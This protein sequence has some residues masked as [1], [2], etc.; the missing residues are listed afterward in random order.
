MSEAGPG[1]PVEGAGRGGPAPGEPLAR[2]GEGPPP[3]WD[4]RPL[5]EAA[6]VVVIGGGII[7]VSTA[8]H[9]CRGG[10]RVVLLEKGR[11]A[12]E[13]SSRNWGFVRQQGRD[14][15]EMPLI[16]ESLRIWGRLAEEL[17]TD[18]GFR[19]AGTLYLAD[20]EEAL[21]RF[22][23]WLEIARAHQLDTRLLGP[24]EV[25]S[26]LPGA[27]GAWRGALATP[28][29]GRAEPARA[30]PALAAGAR[31]AG[32][33]IAEWT[34]AR[35]IVCAAGR[36]DAVVTERGA[37]RAGAVVVAGGAWSRLFCARHGVAFPQL[38]LRGSVLRTGP[39]PAVT[40]RALWSSEVAL[41]PRLDG[42]YTVAH[43]G[44]AEVMLVPDSLRLGHLFRGLY[45]DERRRVRVRLG[46]RFLEELLTPR[47]WDLDRPSPFERERV[48]DPE[49]N[50]RILAEARHNL[51][52]RFPPL[53]GVEV[54]RT[55]AGFIDV[56]PDALPVI[57]GV[58]RL[59][60]LYI[61]SGFSGHG[62]GIGPGAGKVM[63]E[64][65]TGRPP[66]VDLVPFRLERFFSR[67][68]VAAPGQ[69]GGSGEGGQEG[70]R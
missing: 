12:G 18:V 11:L 3:G 35:G 30:V 8:W 36:V 17:G 56:T 53:A 55:W 2:R 6:D 14:A 58:E 16:M 28:S 27:A 47:V 7:G 69:G 45:R 38:K 49:P 39:A 1:T 52:R 65:V 32:A 21:A 59:P 42:G 48:L 62:F 41:R 54:A 37:V 13:Q 66:S 46:K 19:R 23:A 4:P 61:A 64:L 31:A 26:E 68:R 24:D 63:A 40:A 51:G 57:S 43:G 50:G 5:P 67:E 9:L 10:H 60:G 34:A 20:D 29:D 70:A 15:A 22:E 25:R 44:V 33:H